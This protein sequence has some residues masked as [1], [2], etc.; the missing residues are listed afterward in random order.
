MQAGL[1]SICDGICSLTQIF[2]YVMVTVMQLNLLV[3]KACN[4]GKFPF[5]FQTSDILQ[6]KASSP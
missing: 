5:Y 4:L 2:K 6:T 1:F 3:A